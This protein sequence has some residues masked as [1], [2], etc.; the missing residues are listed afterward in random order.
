MDT[1]NKALTLPSGR[2]RQPHFSLTREAGFANGVKDMDWL[3]TNIPCQAACPAHT[4]I[5]DYL[6]EINQG[7]YDEAYLINLV[8]NVFPAVL[9]RVCSRPCEDVCRHGRDGLGEPVAICFSKRAAADLGS[10]KHVVLNP[11]YPQTGKTVAVIGGGPAGLAAARELALYGHK[12]TVYEKYSEAGGMMNQGIPE[13]RLPRETIRKEI[14]QIEML[15]VDIRCNQNIGVDITVDELLA[16]NDA[17]IIA[18]GTLDPNIVDIPG[19]DLGGIQHGLEFLLEANEKGTAKIGERAIVIGGGFTAMD[20]ARTA[21]R[22]NSDV[23]IYYRR[24]REEMSVPADELA[25]VEHE[26]IPLEIMASPMAYLGDAD[27]GIAK[28][29]FVRNEL[30]EPDDSGRRRPVAIADS[31]FEVEVDTVLLATGQW[32]DTSWLG[33]E[34]SKYVLDKDGW[35][36]GGQPVRTEHASLFLA[37]DYSIG[38]STL[39]E[40]IGHA[41]TCAREVDEF[42]MGERRVMDVARIDGSLETGRTHDL[43]A[44]PRQANPTLPLD[45]RSFKAEVER[46]YDHKLATVETSRCYLC[47][48]KFEIDNDI[49]IYCEKCLE[50]KPQEKCIVRIDDLNYDDEGRITGYIDASD[51]TPHVYPLL[52]IDQDECIRCGECEKV[53]PVECISIQKVTRRSERVCD[54]AKEFPA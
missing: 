36:K 19:K 31:D 16:N 52:Y 5:P 39:I 6:D 10:G 54:V 30:G 44:I 48:F 33:P 17:V 13:F 21:L 26:K 35:I 15:G 18:A 3:D 20:C 9:G 12:A 22:L 32:Q 7:N 53:C 37:G 24:S 43:D 38:A 8:D 47:H 23:A 1:E 51:P 49:C 42:L 40:A 34:V 41:K 4:R 28:M 29:R 50:V 45:E 46:G 27:T 11:A 2:N 14:E 25:E